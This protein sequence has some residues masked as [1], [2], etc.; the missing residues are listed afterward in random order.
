MIRVAVSAI[1]TGAAKELNAVASGSALQPELMVDGV[2]LLNLI[3][4][5]WNAQESKLYAQRFP[6]FTL[7][8]NT[9][10]VTIGPTGDLVIAQPPQDIDGIMVIL[11]GSNPT[12]NTYI[13]K[14]DKTWWQ[15]QPS[16]TTTSPIPTGFYYD[17]TWDPTS[18][19]PAGSIYFYPVVD[20]AYDV[21]LSIK[22][23]LAQVTTNEDIGL[24]P[25]YAYAMRMELAARWAQPLRKP[26]T[27][28][29]ESNRVKALNVIT[30]NN[31]ETVRI[32]TR[33]AGMQGRQGGAL[34]NF[35]W[36]DGLLR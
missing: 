20:T 2:E 22:Q 17:P 1:V 3:F 28:Q 32:Q 16:P 36:N 13:P 11:T 29:Q 35:L 12:S 8:V 30:G 33:D 15:N 10:P 23:L 34:P 19:D 4:D 25:A 7:P 26:W 18:A 6:Q 31:A 21:Q 24:P 9:N 27:Q 14:R 5:D